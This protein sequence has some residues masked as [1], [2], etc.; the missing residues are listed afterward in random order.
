ML[1]CSLIMGFET[2]RSGSSSSL[3]SEGSSWIISLRL[4]KEAKSMFEQEFNRMSVSD[5]SDRIEIPIFCSG[6][7]LLAGMRLDGSTEQRW[8]E[9]V[10]VGRNFSE[11]EPIV[12]DAGSSFGYIFCSCRVPASSGV[13]VSISG[14]V[15]SIS[16]LSLRWLKGL[17]ENPDSTVVLVLI[18]DDICSTSFPSSITGLIPIFWKGKYRNLAEDCSLIGNAEMEEAGALSILKVCDWRLSNCSW[19]AGFEAVILTRLLILLWLNE[20][21]WAVSI[22]EIDR[23]K[24]SLLPTKDQKSRTLLAFSLHK[25]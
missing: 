3:L 2:S 17:L 8:E 14:L 7:P 18:C 9:S 13:L 11:F 22:L 4:D 25:H 5:K 24:L 20:W 1:T 19:E 21:D 16:F 23:E 15:W 6:I 10:S 12:L